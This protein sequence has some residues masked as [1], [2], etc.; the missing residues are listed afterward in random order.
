MSVGDGKLGVWLGLG[1]AMGLGFWVERWF[2]WNFFFFGRW[3]GV[4]E[5][6]SVW[7][8]LVGFEGLDGIRFGFRRSNGEAESFWV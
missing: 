4:V 2:V 1:L 8:D 5:A 3:A 6:G 7:V